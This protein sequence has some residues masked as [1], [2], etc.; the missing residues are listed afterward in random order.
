MKGFVSLC[1]VACVESPRPIH[2]LGLEA[3]SVTEPWLVTWVGVVCPIGDVT[4]LDV[5]KSGDEDWY[6][7]FQISCEN[8]VPGGDLPIAA[9]P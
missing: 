4:G 1:G 3:I 2:F 5:Q 6:M 9:R 8:D 7:V